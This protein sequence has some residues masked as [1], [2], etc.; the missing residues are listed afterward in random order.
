[1]CHPALMHMNND[2][3]L[4]KHKKTNSRSCIVKLQ[5]KRAHVV[6]ATGRVL[7]RIYIFQQ[8]RSLFKAQRFTSE[9]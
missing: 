6:A 5:A 9:K 3:M 8:Q 7:G 1:M 2:G 4:G